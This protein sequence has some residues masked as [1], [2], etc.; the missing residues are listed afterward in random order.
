M[1]RFIGFLALA[2]AA[3]GSGVDGSL[4]NQALQGR[5]EA[6][7][8]DGSRV[9]GRYAAGLK[10]GA[11][12]L[13]SFEQASGSSGQWIS[14]APVG[15]PDTFYTSS[16]AY[17]TGSEGDDV[18]L[19]I[20]AD[21]AG[22]NCELRL[23]RDGGF[24]V[25]ARSRSFLVQAPVATLSIDGSSSP[26]PANLP[27]AN[28]AVSAGSLFRIGGGRIDYSFTGAGNK[29]GQWVGLF[30]AGAASTS[31]LDW[32]YVG[33]INSGAQSLP[34]SQAA[35]SGWYTL[36]VFYDGGYSAIGESAAFYLAP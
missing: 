19:T 3:C 22:K 7:T 17:V 29:T 5:I 12:V 13:V 15:T 33:G 18:P 34:T 28:L 31:Y 11:T 8:D 6:A 16:W 35:K 14:M 24:S 23:Y 9:F 36:R 26:P 2:L 10:A 20:A 4:E 30:A 32:K 21:L 1:R 25:I 27:K